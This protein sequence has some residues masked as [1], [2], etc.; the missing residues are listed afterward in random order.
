MKKH[1]LFALGV[2]CAATCLTACHDS[3]GSDDED[4]YVANFYSPKISESVF[5]KLLNYTGMGVYSYVLQDGGSGYVD[6]W[7][8]NTLSS[9][10]ITSTGFDT[11]GVQLSHD[12]MD[13][14]FQG[15]YGGFSPAWTSAND[16]ENSLEYYLPISG[17][18]HTESGSNALICNPGSVCKAL[19]SKHLSGDFSALLAAMS[20]G[21]L[22][23]L[24]VQP[25]KCYKALYD[26]TFTSN[27]NGIDVAALP[28]NTKIVFQIY[29]YVDHFNVSSFKEAINTIK[30][31]ASATASGGKLGGEIVLAESDSNGKVTVNTEWQ[32]L[33]LSSLEKY[34]LYE[35]YI[36]VIN[37]TTGKDSEYTIDANT[38]TDLGYVWVDDITFESANIL[39][40][41][42]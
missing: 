41:I 23:K 1:L 22:Q 28:A 11:T 37:S 35:A 40:K 21:K 42:L 6:V 2:A 36:K 13:D 30:N 34:Y 15:F 20:V 7:H 33:D 8:Y 5:T 17:T 39:S 3:D 19:F 12:Y 4:G 25:N 27:Y 29:G 24:Y 10:D 18:Y 32:E 14:L 16:E 38:N 26:E 9:E 31:A